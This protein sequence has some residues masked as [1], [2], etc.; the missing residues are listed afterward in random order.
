ML[1]F[2][3]GFQRPTKFWVLSDFGNLLLAPA[4]HESLSKG[5]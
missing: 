1:I 2:F 5:D 4:E 3:K